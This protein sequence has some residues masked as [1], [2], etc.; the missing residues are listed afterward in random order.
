[1]KARVAIVD[2]G[3]GNIWSVRNALAEV[4][5]EAEVVAEPA[6][7]DAF[8]KV[9]LP[10]VGAFADA[11]RLLRQTGM[12]RALGAKAAA[13]L[14]ILGVC[15]G[16]QLMCRSS[17]EDGEHQGLGWLDAEVLPLAPAPGIKIPHMGWNSVR[18][19]RASPLVAGI[20]DGTDFYFVHGYHVVCRDPADV[21][22]SCEHG[23]PVAAVLQRGNL[24]AAQFHPEKSQR[25]GLQLL[26]N[27]VESV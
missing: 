24:C 7:L 4:G 16:M 11:M 2:Y 18:F 14:P 1:V 25:G 12:D 3:M 26:K 17:L 13:G 8:G 9:I 27:F 15:L 21:L 19:A 6:R 22:G 20:A 23:Q 5:A 10:G